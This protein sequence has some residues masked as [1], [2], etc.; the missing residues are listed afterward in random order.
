MKNVI[1][2]AAAFALVGGLVLPSIAE[3]RC[4]AFRDTGV[5]VC[6]EGSGGSAERQARAVCEQVTGNSCRTTGNSG[7]CRSS[8]RVQCYDADGNQQ[9]HI[10]PD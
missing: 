5:R 10:N 4:Y 3:A 7:E 1:K 9:R 6:V 2:M 8:G